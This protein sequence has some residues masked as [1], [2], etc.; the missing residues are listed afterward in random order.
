MNAVRCDFFSAFW[1]S[2]VPGIAKTEVTVAG[3]ALDWTYDEI[4]AAYAALLASA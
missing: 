4:V 2:G 1:P 3:P